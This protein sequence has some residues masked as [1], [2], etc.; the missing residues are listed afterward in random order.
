MAANVEARSAM[1]RLLLIRPD[2]RSRVA[3]ST[4]YFFFLLAANSVLKPLRDAAGIKEGIDTLPRLLTLTFAAM[5]VAIPVYNLAISRLRREHVAVAV[6]RA[7]QVSVAIFLGLGLG[8]GRWEKGAFSTAFYVWLSVFNLI[9]V[10]AFRTLMVDLWRER[11]ATRLFGAISLGGT[12]GVVVGA[13]LARWIVHHWSL[14]AAFP[15]AILL[16]EVAIASSRRARAGFSQPLKESGAP[17]GTPG[18]TLGALRLVATVPLFRQMAGFVGLTS[19]ST[20][21]LYIEQGRIIRRDFPTDAARVDAFATIDMIAAVATITAEALLAGRLIRA[22]GARRTLIL[23][24]FA[25]CILF[26]LL[27]VKPSFAV[28]LLAQTMIRA[29]NY[30]IATPA[31]ETL[32]ADLSPE[33]KYRGKSVIDTFAWRGGDFVGIWAPSFAAM[34]GVSSVATALTAGALWTICAVTFALPARPGRRPAPGQDRA[35]PANPSPG[36]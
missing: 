2:E 28:L 8:L 20:T 7:T 30:G 10:A 3:W 12:L 36:A 15:V 11:Q 6:H 13:G 23:L 24:P 31:R 33:L 29:L 22:F 34:I 16:L 21:L 5:A 32:F 26:V 27:H 18:S 35:A 4:A 9:G 14:W 25:A 1:E 19:V 17:R